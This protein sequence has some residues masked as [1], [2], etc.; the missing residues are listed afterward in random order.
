MKKQIWLVR[1]W[2]SF[3]YWKKGGLIKENTLALLIKL[4]LKKI[5]L[6]WVPKFTAEY[7]AKKLKFASIVPIDADTSFWAHAWKSELEVCCLV[8]IINVLVVVNVDRSNPLKN[9]HEEWFVQPDPVVQ[10]VPGTKL[11]GTIISKILGQHFIPEP[12]RCLPIHWCN[13]LYPISSWDGSKSKQHP[14]N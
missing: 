6:Y 3:W 9:F 8:D 12:S 11:R 1:S 2:F 7:V 10:G 4:K 5:D 14:K 13:A